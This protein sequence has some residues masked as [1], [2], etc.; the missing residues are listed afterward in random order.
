MRD[1]EGHCLVIKWSIHQEAI[2]SINAY[3]PNIGVPKYLKQ[4]LSLK[5]EINSSTI[6]AGG[7]HAPLFNIG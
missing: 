6:T 1:K 5:G 2:R 3:A 4:I 7:F